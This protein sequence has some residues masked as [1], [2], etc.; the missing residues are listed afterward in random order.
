M[1]VAMTIG[2]VLGLAAAILAFIFIMPKK[3]DGRFTGPRIGGTPLMQVL[4][5]W[6]HFKKLYIGDVLKFVYIVASV[7][8]LIGGFITLFTF[9]EVYHYSYRDSYYTTESNFGYGLIITIVGPIALRLFYELGMM[10][11]LAVQNIMDINKKLPNLAPQQPEPTY[12][13][14]VY[15]QQPAY[16]VPQQPAYQVPQQPVYQAPQ[17]P[18]YQAPQQP[19]YQAPQQPPYQ[20][21]Q[22]PTYQGSGQTVYPNQF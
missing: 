14:P 1:D 10:A 11:V 12:Q 15:P 3:K 7:G 19:A 2:G 17:Q 18:V 9:E 20:A 6:F 8:C 13:Q 16:Q 4:H 21:P 5:D 22:Q